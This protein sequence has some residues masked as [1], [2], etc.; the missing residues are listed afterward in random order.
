LPACLELHTY[1]SLSQVFLCQYAGALD[2]ADVALVYFNPHAVKL[3]RL[4]EI[5]P[6]QIREGFANPGLEVFN[7]SAKLK[8][9]LF[10]ESAEK[11]VFLMMSSGNYD[12]IDLNEFAREISA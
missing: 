9:R 12:G 1:S 2:E 4:P 8:T 5:S 3:K 6:D 7:E 11:S 10:A